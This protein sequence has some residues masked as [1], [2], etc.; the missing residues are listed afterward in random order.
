MSL[1]ELL[2][3]L[4]AALFGP[5]NTAVHRDGV[6]LEDFVWLIEPDEPAMHAAESRSFPVASTTHGLTIQAAL[7]LE[8]KPSNPSKPRP[9]FEKLR[10]LRL[11]MRGHEK[12]S[13]YS[14]AKTHGF[15]ALAGLHGQPINLDQPI[16]RSVP[17]SAC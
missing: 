10:S 12:G 5:F 2:Q 13:S 3:F 11:V 14:I 6:S 1:D 15:D 17:L 4:T 16:K 8:P 7:G 9:V